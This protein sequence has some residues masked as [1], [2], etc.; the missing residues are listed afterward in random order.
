M[1]VSAAIT[2]N[3]IL[4]RVAVEAGLDAVADPFGSSDQHYVQLKTLLQTACE[5]LCLAHPWEFLTRTLT[6]NTV[7]G[8]ASY[9]LPKDFQSL[10]DNTGWDTSTDEPIY[11][12]SAQ[13][14][15][16]IEATDIDPVSLG[17]RIFG[18][19]ISFT[20]SSFPTSIKVTFEY[21][22]RNFVIP[23]SN[24]L[25]GDDV[26]TSGAD[27]IIF[28]RTLITRYLK[29]LWFE[30]KGIDSQSAQLAFAQSFDML[31]GKDTGGTVLNVGRRGGGR[32]IDYSNLPD[33]GYGL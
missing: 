1:P 23:A 19:K 30:A 12:L 22:S 5:D 17:F 21:I 32:L 15:G 27:I 4:S 33:H 14:W 26:F 3:Q 9:L 7:D 25:Q 6:I 10:V 29:T 18:G 31:I 20:T 11:L 13:Q 2:V 28:D 16:A 24:P 8:M